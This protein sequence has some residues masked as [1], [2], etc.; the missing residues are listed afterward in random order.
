MC[1]VDF[2]YCLTVKELCLQGRQPT[3]MN[4]S[5]IMIYEETCRNKLSVDLDDR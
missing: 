4:K 5:E 3:N 2:N 1:P